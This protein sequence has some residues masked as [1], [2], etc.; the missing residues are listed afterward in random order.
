ML[1][2]IGKALLQ[3]LALLIVLPVVIVVVLLALEAAHIIPSPWPAIVQVWQWVAA[4][5]PLAVLGKALAAVFGVWFVMTFIT[6]LLDDAFYD[7]PRWWH[8]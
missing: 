6:S 7:G 3:T 2:H 1:K 8:Y 5:G 4:E